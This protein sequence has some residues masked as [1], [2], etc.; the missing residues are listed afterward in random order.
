MTN[1]TFDSLGLNVKTLGAIKNINYL[2][3]MPVQGEVIPLILRGKDALVSAQTGSGKTAAFTIPL[4]DILTRNEDAKC[5]VVAPTRELA[6]QIQAVF[7]ELAQGSEIKNALIVGGKMMV[8]QLK[9]LK[10]NPRFIIGTP[11]RLND[12]IKRKS[13]DLSQTKY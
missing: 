12:H 1:K 9:K 2:A 6:Q 4:L 8:G 13:L 11:G 5:L 3:P 7:R 10:M